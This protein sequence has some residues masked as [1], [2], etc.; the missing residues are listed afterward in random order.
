MHLAAVQAPAPRFLTKFWQGLPSACLLGDI[1]CDRDMALACGKCLFQFRW[2]VIVMKRSPAMR[3]W[4]VMVVGRM[5]QTGLSSSGC[6]RG[7]AV[8]CYIRPSLS[9]AFQRPA[10]PPPI[11][12]SAACRFAYFKAFQTPAPSFLT[13]IWQSRLS[14]C[15]LRDIACDGDVRWLAETLCFRFVKVS[16]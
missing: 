7:Q 11:M 15:L 8:D 2:N 13:Q 5:C 16:L 14:A 9:F 6:Q 3:P 1:A 4:L 10:A 12:H